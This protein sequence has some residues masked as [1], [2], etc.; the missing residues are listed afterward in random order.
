MF[1][2]GSMPIVHLKTRALAP[3][4]RAL[5]DRWA[6]EIQNEYDSRLLEG[7]PGFAPFSSGTKKDRAL[8]TM[9]AANDTFPLLAEL[10]EPSP[11][12]ALVPVESFSNNS[13]TKAAASRLKNLFDKYGSDKADQDYHYLYGAILEDSQTVTDIL[14]IGLGTNNVD[15]VSN[16]GKSGKPGA[17]LRAFRDFLPDARVY[18]ADV[19]KRI[20]FEENRIKTFFV[21]QT[22]P[23]SF[24]QISNAVKHKFDLIIDDGL[25]APNANIASLAFALRNLKQN[26]W[27]VV[28][29]INFPALP[30]WDV[31]SALLPDGYKW[32][33]VAAKGAYLFVVRRLLA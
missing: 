33:R 25:H 14:E 20:L 17:S 32:W 19:D 11:E 24:D 3:F 15:V 6:D 4:K 9:Q 26:G 30:V 8:L 22:D 16:M 5:M 29:D 7:L 1:E 13:A 28:E 27:F 12:R 18:G 10:L 31:V 2:E 23:K 21:D